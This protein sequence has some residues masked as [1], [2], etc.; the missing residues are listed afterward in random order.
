MKL[1]IHK[2][3]KCELQSLKLLKRLQLKR[4]K[5]PSELKVFF[6]WKFYFSSFESPFHWHIV[7][8]VQHIHIRNQRIGQEK[9][10]RFQNRSIYLKNYIG[11]V[12]S[13]VG[14]KVILVT[15]DSKYS[16]VRNRS[17]T[18]CIDL[19]Q[20]KLVTNKFRLQ[21]HH[22]HRY[23]PELL[24]GDNF[25]IMMTLNWYRWQSRISVINTYGQ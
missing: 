17:P 13:D 2:S 23:N 5:H 12:V 14:D 4:S 25:W 1:G 20:L 16:N 8:Q 24:F 11:D 22:Q 7:F 9:H 6:W 18:F 15:H 3:N 19:L 10:I 21:H